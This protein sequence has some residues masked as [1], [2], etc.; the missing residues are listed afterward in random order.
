MFA[1]QI[2]IGKVFGTPV[3]LDATFILAVVMWGEHY[4][5]SGSLEQFSY[6]LLLVA[7]IA[8]SILLHEFGH[9]AAAAY[10]RVRTTHVELNAC[11]GLCH[12]SGALP[13]DRLPNVVV[14]LA[15]PAVTLV[16]WLVCT[17]LHQT[18]FDLPESFGFI[19][20]IDRLADLVWHIGYLNWWMLLF[21]LLPS[22]PLD[23]GRSLAHILSRWIGYDRA[24]RFVAYC[25][26]LVVAW[27][28]L[29]AMQGA[30]WTLLLVF[31]L[32]Q[33]NQQVL[34]VHKGPSWTRWN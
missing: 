4:F 11:G 20:G 13:P 7:G 34:D 21:N 10:Y 31:Y 12:L 29:Q 1:H 26:L 2:G 22:H 18:L 8:G 28:L 17:G 33:A 14:L 30:Y 3:V 15:G 9:A 27:V 19:G 25:G 23:G 32:F 24:M 5:T 16:L 6:G